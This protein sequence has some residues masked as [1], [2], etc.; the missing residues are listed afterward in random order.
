M[1]ECGVDEESSITAQIVMLLNH[2]DIRQGTS[3]FEIR[4]EEWRR[5]ASDHGEKV[6]ILHIKSWMNKL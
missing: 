1:I 4:L 3:L 5:F 6:T 2:Y